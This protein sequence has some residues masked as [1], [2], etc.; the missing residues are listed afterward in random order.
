MRY[1]IQVGLLCL[2]LICHVHS[3]HAAF[4]IKNVH[5]TDDNLSAAAY[6]RNFTNEVSPALPLADSTHHGQVAK[7]KRNNGLQGRLAFTFGMLGLIFQ[8]IG[9]VAI[10]WLEKGNTQARPCYYRVYFRGC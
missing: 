4:W 7:V 1:N 9:V 2:L 3:A 8:P 6:Q 5:G 10:F